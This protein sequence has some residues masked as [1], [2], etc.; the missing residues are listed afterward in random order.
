MC[1]FL[2]QTVTLLVYSK[3]RNSLIEFMDFLVMLH[4]IR[5]YFFSN[6]D[7]FAQSEKKLKKW[8]QDRRSQSR[9]INHLLYFVLP[10]WEFDFWEILYS[11]LR[12]SVKPFVCVPFWKSHLSDIV[13][14]L[15]S[16]F[17]CLQ[18]TSLLHGYISAFT[19]LTFDP[20]RKLFFDFGLKFS[21][22]FSFEVTSFNDDTD[23]KKNSHNGNFW[24]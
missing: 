2:A 13:L 5:L 3:L 24:V 22:M 4:L 11:W 10:G 7:A 1:K 12:F 20:H 8:A 14:F 21:K 19:L 17:I 16:F 23:S 18:D 6:V 9:E 15:I